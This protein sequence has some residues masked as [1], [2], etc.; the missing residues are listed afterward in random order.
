MSEN[1][2]I[3][4]ENLSRK[5]QWVGSYVPVKGAKLYVEQHGSGEPLVCLHN[6]GA[7]GR[8]RFYPLLPI[9]T[10]HYTCYLADLRGHGRSTNESGEWT[11]ELI[12]QDIMEL[13]DQLHLL[14][15]RFLAASSGA[16]AMLRVA[17]Y[18]PQLVQAMALDS[19][20]YKIPVASRKY[21][22]DP[23]ALSPKLKKYYE[24]ANELYGPAYGP[25]LA[26]I[27]Y[28]FRLP[29]CDINQPLESLKEISA[30]TLLIAGDHDLFFPPEIHRDM[31]QT[32]PR[33]ELLI[34]PETGHIVME[35]YPER[36][37]ELTIEFFRRT[38]RS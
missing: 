35:F 38:S 24:D 32:I 14:R 2:L 7:N 33:S 28:D 13:C 15:A 18:A 5:T 27:F 6:F 3:T 1:T 25:R 10:E 4:D 34:F 30:P 11:H 21:Y 19:G 26:K 37:A 22:K 12:S 16:M 31:A 8:S 20:T 23:E 9:L 36:V 29:E 17:Q